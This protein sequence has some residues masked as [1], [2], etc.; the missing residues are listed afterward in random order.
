M[1]NV[2][3]PLNEKE[4]ASTFRVLH[5]WIKGVKCELDKI[6]VALTDLEKEEKMC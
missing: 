5:R 4:K 2:S 3:E 1:K 6:D